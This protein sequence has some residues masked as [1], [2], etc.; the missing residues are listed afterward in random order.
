MCAVFL[1]ILS[2][3]G[4]TNLVFSS[5]YSVIFNTKLSSSPSSSLCEEV[6]SLDSICLKNDYVEA[7]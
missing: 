7:F 3:D 6:L 5:P 2:S 1:Y 4:D